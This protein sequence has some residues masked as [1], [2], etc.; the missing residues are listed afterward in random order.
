MKQKILIVIPT[1]LLKK[2]KRAAKSA[3]KDRSA[4]ICAVLEDKFFRD[5][6]LKANA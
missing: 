5:E 2:V 1:P 6:M 3:G 4:F